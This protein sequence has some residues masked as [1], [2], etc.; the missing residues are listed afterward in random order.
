ME[1]KTTSMENMK[2]IN[3]TPHDIVIIKTNGEKLILQKSSNPARCES[4]REVV[5]HINGIPINVTKFGKTY[6]LP[7]PQ[8]NTVFIVSRI[9]AES[10]RHRSDLFIVDETVR[11][12]NGVIIGCKSL[13]RV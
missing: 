8:P 9:V 7:D 4:S 1:T 6:N 3:C 5:G 10:N 11:D 13:A 12:E 2:I